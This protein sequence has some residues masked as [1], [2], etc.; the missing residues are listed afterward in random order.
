MRSTY[1]NYEWLFLFSYVIFIFYIIR[2]S[3]SEFYRYIAFIYYFIMLFWVMYSLWKKYTVQYLLM[4]LNIFAFDIL[5]GVSIIV[6]SRDKFLDLKYLSDA[7][8]CFIPIVAY[9]WLKHNGSVKLKKT[10]L[11]TSTLIW[12]YYCIK[13]ILFYNSHVNAARNMASN[14]GYYGNVAIGGGYALGF[15]CAILAAYFFEK[16]LYENYKRKYGLFCALCCLLVFMT[17]STITTIVMLT[18]FGYSVLKFAFLKWKI[19]VMLLLSGLI[20]VVVCLIASGI[21]AEILILTRNF[22]S[23]I[24]RPYAWRAV[25]IIDA[26]MGKRI[27]E[28]GAIS[29]RAIVYKKSWDAFWLNPFDGQLTSGILFGNAN[30]GG[31][32]EFLDCFAQ[33][34][35]FIGSSYLSIYIIAI[36]DIWSHMR[37]HA[38]IFVFIG[39]FLLNPIRVFHIMFVTMLMIPLFE[40][41]SDN[42]KY[43]YCYVDK[44]ISK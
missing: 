9:Q 13:A 5:I 2:R 28:E 44:C 34:G 17:E 21:A 11:S 15:G 14:I 10:I 24:S 7:N 1:K 37:Y 36:K 3:T 6:F 27:Q 31:H 16:F 42:K 29:L 33:W 35:I 41:W 25:E 39:L 38:F 40:T 43:E 26:I 20:I 23:E 18:G 22:F 32:S 30:V 4:L 12:L 19:G 8:I